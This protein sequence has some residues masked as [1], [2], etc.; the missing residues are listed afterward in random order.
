MKTPMQE[1]IEKITLKTRGGITFL[2]PSISNSD[3]EELLEKEKQHIM[4]AFIEANIQED[5][6]HK[7]KEYAEYYYNDL[8]GE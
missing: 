8:Y 7:N 2:L 3:I 5:I 6:V 1:L 4:N